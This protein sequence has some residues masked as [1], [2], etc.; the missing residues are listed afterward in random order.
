MPNIHAMAGMYANISALT[1]VRE[2]NV[3]VP[4]KLSARYAVMGGMS[5]AYT[6]A[7]ALLIHNADSGF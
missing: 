5:N 2:V 1:P 6:N 7:H 4:V 3:L